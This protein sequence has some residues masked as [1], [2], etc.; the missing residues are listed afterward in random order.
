M[1]DD[2]QSHAAP[3]PTTKRK[4]AEDIAARQAKTSR[5]GVHSGRGAVGGGGSGAAATPAA[6][7]E[8]ELLDLVN[9]M[10]QHNRK[11]QAQK[12]TYVPR[13]HSVQA[14]RQVRGRVGAAEGGKRAGGRSAERGLSAVRVVQWEKQSGR[15]WYEL[16]AAE[17]EMANEEITAIAATV[18]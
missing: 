4:P 14:I 13:L 3:V 6:A 12:T 15:K 18:S 2:A 16:T 11:V 9:L 10:K 1:Y 8:G 7:P 17:R 5:G